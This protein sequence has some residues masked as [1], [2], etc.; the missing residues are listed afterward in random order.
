MRM[1]DVA[2]EHTSA[3]KSCAAGAGGMY[4]PFAH[5]AVKYGE[6]AP[7]VSTEGTR[8]AVGFEAH[9]V[10]RGTVVL[11]PSRAVHDASDHSS[12]LY[13][14]AFGH[15]SYPSQARHPHGRHNWLPRSVRSCTHVR[16]DSLKKVI[17]AGGEGK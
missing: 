14:D 17:G 8:S 4:A 16:E 2:P 10:G 12:R 6:N 15:D 5:A 11:P 1:N 3:V 13:D 7:R 9:P